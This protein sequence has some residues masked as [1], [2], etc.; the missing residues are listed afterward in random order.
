LE[1]RLINIYIN[2][3]KLLALIFELQIV[4]FRLDFVELLR[5]K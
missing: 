5:K 2:Y 1:L 4:A 3:R